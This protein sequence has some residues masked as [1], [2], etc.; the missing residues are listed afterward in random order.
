MNK[1]I[2]IPSLFILFILSACTWIDESDET[3]SWI[4]FEEFQDL[5]DE[6]SES[7]DDSMTWENYEDI[8]VDAT[9][10]DDEDVQ[11]DEEAQT[12]ESEEDEIT[13]E[14]S[15]EEE[16]DIEEEDE[17]EEENL[18]LISEY[19]NFTALYNTF[20]QENINDIVE[21]DWEYEVD[22]IRWTAWTTAEVSYADED[23]NEYIAEMTVS[24]DNWIV[25]VNSFDLISEEEDS[26]EEEQDTE[27]EDEVEEENLYLISEYWNFTALYNTFIQEN[28]ND[29]VESD[30]EYEVDNIRWI[31]WNTA[32]ISYTEEDWDE[33]LAEITV[34]YDNWI[35]NVNSF[36]LISWGEDSDEEDEVEEIDESNWNIDVN[37]HLNEDWSINF[38]S[39]YGTYIQ[40]NISDIA[41]FDDWELQVWDISW[42]AWNTAQVSISY[43]GETVLLEISLAFRDGNVVIT[44]A[45]EVE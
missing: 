7:S 20:I 43:N 29:I 28:I 44:S 38:T 37:M 16:Q 24:Y 27:E 14:D 39:L 10:L 19:W 33:Y 31:A 25:N 35:V 8:Q 11:E 34:S 36:D 13:E 3:Q 45:E 40:E 2:L 17:V 4:S 26:D 23:W 42:L 32:Q 9:E 1:Q 41:G 15:D 30:W 22:N 21:S 5:V 6:E 18:Y 12:D